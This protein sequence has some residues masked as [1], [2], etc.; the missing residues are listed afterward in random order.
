MR[1]R[2]Y[3][4]L[5]TGRFFLPPLVSAFHHIC[6]N[7]WEKAGNERQGRLQFA[8]VNVAIS[9]LPNMTNRLWNVNICP[10]WPFTHLKW[11]LASLDGSMLNFGVKALKNPGI[12]F[13]P[14]GA[15]S[16]RLR[17][18]ARWGSEHTGGCTP[19]WFP[20]QA[21]ARWLLY[22][23]RVATSGPTTTRESALVKF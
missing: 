8:S 14:G 23:S 4:D 3:I 17:L 18:V 5:V 2:K 13:S 15:P 10:C 20:A 7:W 9:G 22:A 19:L 12:N 6:Y 1:N 16:G 21:Q 11:W